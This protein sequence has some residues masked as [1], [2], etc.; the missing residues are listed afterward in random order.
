[1]KSKALLKRW[2]HAGE[3]DTD[4]TLVYRPAGY[5]LPPARGRSGLEFRPDH[6]YR[7]V[8]IGRR[9]GSAVTVGSWQLDAEHDDHVT[10]TYDGEEE[11]LEIV[12]V[13]DDRLV[14]KKKGTATSL[15]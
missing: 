5:P 9:D 6:S 3:E 11:S 15:G 14:V 12:S 8:G 2:V 10:I 13:E 1:M 4:D 7:R